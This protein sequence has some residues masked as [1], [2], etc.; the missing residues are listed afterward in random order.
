MSVNVRARLNEWQRRARREAVLGSSESQRAQ[1]VEGGLEMIPV[2]IFLW[3]HG[4][5]DS[6]NLGSKG[7]HRGRWGSEPE[8]KKNMGIRGG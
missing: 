2:Q 1:Q 6:A 7:F 4:W 8:C 5:G 3:E